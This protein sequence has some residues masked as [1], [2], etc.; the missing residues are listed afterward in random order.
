MAR[1]LRANGRL[2]RVPGT[3]RVVSAQNPCGCCGDDGTGPPP[4]PEILPLPDPELCGDC[5]NGQIQIGDQVLVQWSS[6]LYVAPTSDRQTIE[7]CGSSPPRFQ[8][9]QVVINGTIVSP[10]F[11]SGQGTTAFYVIDAVSLTPNQVTTAHGGTLDM[12]VEPTH[13]VGR[14]R[15]LQWSCG[16]P[17]TTFHQFIPRVDFV[18]GRSGCEGG[19]RDRV[20]LGGEI[21][22]NRANCVSGGSNVTYPTVERSFYFLDPDGRVT[23]SLVSVTPPVEQFRFQV[24]PSGARASSLLDP[25]AQAALERQIGGCGACGDSPL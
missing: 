1:L 9:Y 15:N 16:N 12:V 5:E 3:G 2:Q 25:K 22:A 8:P 20:G 11:F 13:A 19:I 4:P 6:S 7:Q 14:N 23:S 17:M 21:T 18:G 24:F 10:P